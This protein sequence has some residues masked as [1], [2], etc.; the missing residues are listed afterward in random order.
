MAHLPPE[1]LVHRVRLPFEAA[2]QLSDG[3]PDDVRTR[4]HGHGFQVRLDSVLPNDWAPFP[5]AALGNLKTELA[6]AIAPLDYHDLNT[7]L[8]SPSDARLAEHVF[9]T[10]T[11]PGHKHVSVQST[12]RQGSRHDHTGFSVWRSYRLE[13][14]HWLPNVPS[15]HKCGRLHGHGFEIRL[16]AWVASETTDLDAGYQD[17]DTAFAPIA[18]TLDH[19]CLNDLAGLTVP[20]SELLAEWLWQKLKPQLAGLTRI[21]VH[22]TPQSGAAYDGRRFS[23]FRDFSLDSAVS[24]TDAPPCDPRRRIH[25]HTYR[26]RLGLSAPVDRVFGW[27]MDF[28]DVKRLFEPIVQC[29]DHQPLHE[30]ATLARADPASIA[31][32]V[33]AQTLPVLPS[34]DRIEL[35]E[36]PDAGVLL[37]V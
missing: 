23:I 5:G 27:T 30:L 21:G 2:R 1:R 20:T 31:R 36:T 25:G 7:I 13:A 3:A 4:R 26:L 8:R 15:G 28:G 12:A 14:A 16:E 24:L 37:K 9:N 29:L 34:I 10:L 35:Y 32:W 33:R 11:V 6:A 22:E 18:A 17:L 19:V